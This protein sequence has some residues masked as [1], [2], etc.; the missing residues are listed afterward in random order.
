MN[1][2]PQQA[3]NIMQPIPAVSFALISV[4]VAVEVSSFAPFGKKPVEAV[5]IG[6]ATVEKVSQ[7]VR[8]SVKLGGHNLL[9]SKVG[10]TVL[11]EAQ[12]LWVNCDYD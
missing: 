10:V 6:A 11:S 12:R 8:G 2:I 7:I 1:G 3:G 9:R 5:A 4:I